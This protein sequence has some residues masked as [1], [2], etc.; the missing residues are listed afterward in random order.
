MPYWTGIIGAQR[1]A[2]AQR[3]LPLLLPR[4]PVTL[5]EDAEPKEPCQVSTQV[6]VQSSVDGLMG[7]LEQ[8]EALPP[9]RTHRF[10]C[11]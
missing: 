4:F 9:T 11:A 5:K 10:G 8:E 7:W 6:A 1:E 3:G 2:N